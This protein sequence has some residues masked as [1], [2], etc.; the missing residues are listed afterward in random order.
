MVTTTSNSKDNR[1]K[2]LVRQNRA[3]NPTR[4]LGPTERRPCSATNRPSNPPHKRPHS[5]SSPTR[6]RRDDAAAPL[7]GVAAEASA[8]FEAWAE[9]LE[10]FVFEVV[11]DFDLGLFA[12]ESVSRIAAQLNPYTVWAT[13]DAS[14]LFGQA[15]IGA[16]E[17][18]DDA[19][20]PLVMHLLISDEVAFI[21]MP[22]VDGWIDLGG[23]FEEVVGELTTLLGADSQEFADPASFGQ[24]LDCLQT[25]GGSISTASHEG[26][27][28]WG[29]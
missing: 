7:D 23:E 19:A 10:S 27:A 3:H 20:E 14:S 8:A 24:A 26:E 9:N 28:V 18:A 2:R 25:L 5:K 21:S 13:I 29:H 1:L 15:M 16:D 17:E 22:Q 6:Q 11:V 12:F 4:R